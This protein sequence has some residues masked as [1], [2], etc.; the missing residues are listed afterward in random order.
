MALSFATQEAIWLRCLLKNIGMKEDGSSTI[1]EDNNGAIELSRNPKF[2]DRTKHI[3]V[4]H[5]FV[6]EQVNQNNISVKYCPTQNMLADGMTKALT[7]DTFQRLR[8]LLGVKS[9]V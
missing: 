8:D 2:H 3:D 6:R 9:V 7:K 1:F 4:A 5:H